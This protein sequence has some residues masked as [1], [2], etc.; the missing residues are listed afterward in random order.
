MMT[1]SMNYKMVAKWI[2]K[3]RMI[4]KFKSQLKKKKVIWE[5]GWRNMIKNHHHLATCLFKK[6]WKMKK[7]KFLKYG[8][9]A[10][11][12]LSKTKLSRPPKDLLSAI[13][14]GWTFLPKISW[15]SSTLLNLQQDSSNQLK[16][17]NLFLVNKKWNNKKSL[18]LKVSGMTNNKL[19]NSKNNKIRS[20]KNQENH[21]SNSLKNKILQL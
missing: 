13:T 14:I 5:N 10:K 2:N 4:N 17:I 20:L 19:M 8:L 6:C 7:N 11:K 21:G 15:S 3:I 18:A 16:F 1:K 12:M 9:I